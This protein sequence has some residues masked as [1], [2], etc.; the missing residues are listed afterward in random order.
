MSLAGNLSVSEVGGKSSLGFVRTKNLGIESINA[1]GAKQVRSP[2]ES[3]FN[4]SLY[5][6]CSFSV[7]HMASC[8]S[9]SLQV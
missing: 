1:E 6:F 3:E 7:V 8:T 2:M 9:K 5:C 4:K